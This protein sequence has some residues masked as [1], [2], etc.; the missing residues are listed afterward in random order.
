MKSNILNIYISLLGAFFCIILI[1]CRKDTF[2]DEPGPIDNPTAE[3]IVDVHGIVLDKN[4]LPL[5]GVQIS[6]GDRV[7]TTNQDG[8]F[9]L[10]Q[11]TIS[12]QGTLV[13]ASK[14]DFFDM[15]RIV[16]PHK[17]QAKVFVQL[18][19]NERGEVS[20]FQSSEA[21]EISM[22]GG[23]KV[24]FEAN[25]FLDIN[26]NVFSGEVSVYTHWYNPTDI[27]LVLSSPASLEGIDNE[28]NEVV[29]ASFGMV[30]VE[31]ENGNGESLKLK[32][33]VQA[34]LNFPIPDEL[35][36]NAPSSIPLWSV[37]EETGFWVE[38]GEA[39]IEGNLYVG[40]VRHFSFWNC[41]DPF[42]LVEIEGYLET[43]GGIPITNHP[44]KITLNDQNTAIG[45]TNNLGY[46]S[47]KV[48]ADALLQL[49]VTSC[50]TII[51]DIAIGPFSS[52]TDL[53]ILSMDLLIN[54]TSVVGSLVGCINQPLDGA[55]GLINGYQ[56]VSTDVDG[57]FAS[58]LTACT[59]MSNSIKFYD[60]AEQNV[61]ELIDLDLNIDEND[62]GT[63]IVCEELEEYL[64]FNIDGGD[65]FLVE[66]PESYII[67]NE[68]IELKA[69][70]PTANYGFHIN[71][72]SVE[73]G[74]FNPTRANG[75]TP[76]D[77]GNDNGTYVYCQDAAFPCDQFSVDILSVDLVEEIITGTFE[78][79]LRYGE[80]TNP[81]GGEVYVTGSFR[82]VITDQFD[83]ASVSGKIW[84]DLDNNG[85]R[86]VDEE[87]ANVGSVLIIKD[88][89]VDNGSFGTYRVDSEDGTYL[90]EGLRPGTYFLRVYT[91]QY[92]LTSFQAG[93]DP[94]KD[95]DFIESSN[96]D[97][98]VSYSFTLSDGEF[99]EHL[100][101]GYAA[102]TSVACGLYSV[103]CS[104]DLELKYNISGGLGPFTVG[105]SDGQEQISGRDSSF[106][107]E[108]G[109][110]YVVTVTDALGNTS[111]CSR[112]VESFQNTVSGYL[113]DDQGGMIDGLFEQ[114]IDQQIEGVQ[115]KLFDSS[116]QLIKEVL[117]DGKSY[118][119]RDIPFGDYFIE[120]EIPNGYDITILDDD[121]NYGNDIDPLT[122]RSEVFSITECF[123]YMR[124]NAG[125]KAQ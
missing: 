72:G 86:D 61:S 39:T 109:G 40:S 65:F 8:V 119:L 121:Q 56:M 112:D 26:G 45:Y 43:T 80:D 42:D 6:I 58:V 52:D 123:T 97:N 64:T 100:D 98:Y 1:G 51:A 101:L 95:N 122:M 63:V 88:S 110:N 29:L 19:M 108:N 23:A 25:S 41:D 79:Y 114:V 104:P 74:Q 94:S 67:N 84:V 96:S 46:F 116:E 87:D 4:Q 93:G 54:S 49:S 32:D 120:V 68:R 20:K 22:N 3:F 14:N 24:N 118:H 53:G 107:F 31:I 125:F 75:Y 5:E 66:D 82:S 48:P 102:P 44:I 78:G 76:P 89:D 99:L 36:S 9:L 34:V 18:E 106:F 117:G 11:T 71:V 92:D 69:N 124:V 113:W 47:G 12:D 81:G 115:I 16:Y 28:E 91:P 77:G 15:F 21:Q 70:H 17:T 105:L 57:S 59:N 10:R 33:G 103:G 30:A 83:E 27:D 37:D 50:N 2:I 62:L 55:Y 7:K 90:F 35:I 73:T 85:I 38:E 13:K 60:G 111:T